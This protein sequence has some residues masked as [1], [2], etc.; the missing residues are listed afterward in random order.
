MAAV[1]EGSHLSD[2]IA[3][4]EDN[5]F[6]R[7]KVTILAGEEVELGTILEEG[8]GGYVACTTEANA[9]AIA[10]APAAPGSGETIDIPALVRHC[11]VLADG[12]DYETDSLDEDTTNAA[13]LAL[14]IVVEDTVKP[15]ELIPN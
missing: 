8:S 10:L 4:E 12:L 15:T 5:Y 7:A 11:K 13:L 14:G 9:C 6:S 3:W 2:V 1:N